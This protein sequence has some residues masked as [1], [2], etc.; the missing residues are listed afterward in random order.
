MFVCDVH[1]N[2]TVFPLS[3]IKQIKYSKLTR[4]PLCL[5]APPTSDSC[6]RNLLSAAKFWPQ[7]LLQFFLSRTRYSSLVIVITINIVSLLKLH[8]SVNVAS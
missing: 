3:W 4:N 2:V 6:Y 5:L 8:V 1:F 7:A